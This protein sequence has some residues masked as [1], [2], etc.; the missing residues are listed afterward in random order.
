MANEV[1][2][3]VVAR[4]KTGP[5]MA[6]AKKNAE[7]VAKSVKSIGEIAGGIVAANTFQRLGAAAV[8]AFTDTIRAAS[9]LEQAIGGTKAVFGDSS[10]AI[11]AWGQQS[12][13]SAGLSEREFREMTTLV[14]GQLKR[15]TGD[16]DFASEAFDPADPNR[17]RPRGHLRRNHPAGDG[18]I[19]RRV[20]GEADPAERFNLNLKQSVVAAKAV[21]LGLAAVT[22]QV[23]EPAKAQAMLAL[24][25]E[26]SADAQGQFA[27]E[28]RHRGGRSTEDDRR[29]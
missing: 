21:E 20:A 27:R 6:S 29:D 23:S 13:Q 17:G 8:H 28:G 2:V 22:S 14:G 18:R 12:A 16:I 7:G 15:M 26:Q 10:A 24:I 3:D 11:D 5:G 19:R 1:G 25:T 4:D 9:G